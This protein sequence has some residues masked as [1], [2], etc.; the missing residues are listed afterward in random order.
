M[1]IRNGG[2]YA[3]FCITWMTIT[4]SNITTREVLVGSPSYW[5]EEL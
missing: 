2:H 3:Y 1:K 5:K 4:V